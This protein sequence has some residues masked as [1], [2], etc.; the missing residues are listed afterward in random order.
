MLSSKV[1]EM[2]GYKAA[3]EM[4][5]V[6]SSYKLS[7][8]EHKLVNMLISTLNSHK[9]EETPTCSIR[10]QDYA[11]L[12]GIRVDKA[13]YALVE[14]M[15]TLWERE[16]VWADGSKKCRWLQERADLEGGIIE[17][18]FSDRVFKSLT[19]LKNSTYVQLVNEYSMVLKGS[20]TIRMFEILLAERYIK[21]WDNNKRIYKITL[22]FSEL[23]YRLAVSNS[24]QEYRV[25]K[26]NVL[27][28]LVKELAAKDIAVIT[29]QSVKL[30]R[31][32]DAVEFRIN[33]LIKKSR[34]KYEG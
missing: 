28:K 1:I 2:K 17:V 8:V 30:G 21:N 6:E 23:K 27:D 29:Y 32:V 24:Y 34:G 19:D 10:V 33:W 3:K 20:Y 22:P 4:V 11:S 7:E 16:I 15:D 18:K 26:V 12:V 14:A 9:E 25:F 13:K 31:R 5:L